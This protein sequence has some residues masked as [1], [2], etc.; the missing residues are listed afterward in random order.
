MHDFGWLE[1]SK[2]VAFE[3][4]EAFCY[5]LEESLMYQSTSAT[6]PSLRWIFGW[7]PKTFAALLMSA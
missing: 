1:L 3:D 7:N 2:D 6:R 5:K 4:V